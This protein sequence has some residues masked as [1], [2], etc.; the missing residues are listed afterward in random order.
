MGT[1]GKLPG[2]YVLPYYLKELSNYTSSLIIF[3][4]EYAGLYENIDHYLNDTHVKI[5]D[6]KEQCHY[7]LTNYGRNIAFCLNN[8]NS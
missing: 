1:P 3:T 5:D 7:I 4:D 6:F 8:L 2:F